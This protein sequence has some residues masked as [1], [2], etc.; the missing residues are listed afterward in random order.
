MSVLYSSTFKGGQVNLKSII[1]QFNGQNLAT[2]H[3]LFNSVK[4]NIGTQMK[5]TQ[6]HFS[7][8]YFITL[9]DSLYYYERFTLLL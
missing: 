9:N 4:Y 1:G 8:I 6:N 2:I 3:G 7:M 5:N